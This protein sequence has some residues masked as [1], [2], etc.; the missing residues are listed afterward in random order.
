MV[1]LTYL[2]FILL[3]LW[4]FERYYLRGRHNGEYPVPTDPGVV[5]HF[6]GSQGPE[7]QAVITQVRELAEQVS[8]SVR[9][10]QMQKARA[11][12]DSMSDGQSYASKFI[13]AD[14]GGV[15]AEWVIA[16]GADSSTVTLY[17]WRRLYHGQP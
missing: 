2:V 14:A 10:N 11:I 16:P 4:V 7:Q 6:T 13:P 8:R 5:R 9:K 12:I 3:A 15:P 1:L 17:P